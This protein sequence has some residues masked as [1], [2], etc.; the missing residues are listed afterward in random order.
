V[1][2]REK[3]RERRREERERRREERERRREERERRREE[4]ERNR[5]RDLFFAAPTFTNFTLMRP[6]R[7]AFQN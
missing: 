5:E 4:R 2:V 1:Y 6:R 3:E 7:D